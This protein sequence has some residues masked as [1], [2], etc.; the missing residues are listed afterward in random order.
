MKFNL[1]ARYSLVILSLII[2][3]TIWGAAG[4]F[5]AVPLT[6][7]LFIVLSNFE[8]TR[9]AAILMSQ[10]GRIESPAKNQT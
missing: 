6:A 10:N 5:L 1:Q 9:P 3:G 8:A 7:I 4:M 2:W